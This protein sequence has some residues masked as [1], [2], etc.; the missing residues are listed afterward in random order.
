MEA[1]LNLLEI[2]C[3]ITLISFVVI[4]IG[5]EIILFVKKL[6][7]VSE[8]EKLVNTNR[9][10]IDYLQSQVCDINRIDFIDSRKAQIRDYFVRTKYIGKLENKNLIDDYKV[11][12]GNFEEMKNDFLN[13]R[14]VDKFEKYKETLTKY[15]HMQIVLNTYPT[16]KEA[17]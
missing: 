7:R 16:K 8:L 17:K 9:F 6:K 4:A 2:I 15:E 5:T 3:Y 14:N 12:I 10:D 11:E 13:Y 1:V